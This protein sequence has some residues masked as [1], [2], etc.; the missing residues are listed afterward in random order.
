MLKTLAYA[1]IAAAAAFATP[2]AQAQETIRFAVTDVDGLESL[3]REFGPFKA[4]FE[5]ISGLKM[6]F[7]AVSGRTAAVEAM[8]ADQIDFVLTGPAEY[9]VF[10][11]RTGAVPVVGWQRPDYF[12]Q[13]AVLASGPIKTVADLK[14]K[15]ISFGEIGSTSQ[16]LGP[17]QALADFGLKYNVDYKPI[18]VKRNVAA[19]AMKRGDI[20]AIGLNLGHLASIRKSDPKT[21][22]AVVARGRDLPNDVMIASPKVKP[23]VL[24]KVR[25]T[26][27]DN[28]QEL[29]KA[30][31]S[32]TDDNKKFLGGV[33]LPEVKDT[34]YDYVRSIY[35]TIGITEFNKFIE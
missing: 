22:F 21:G 13:I 30:V 26:F 14:G 18:F 34:D 35:Q 3:Q 16:H 27:L 6:Q 12:A 29:M 4:A 23:E 17:A 15:T 1:F 25:K 28:G 10:K 32:D 7:F 11:A 20:A 31:V 8:A 33:F 5:R 2:A 19:E 24:A 9:V